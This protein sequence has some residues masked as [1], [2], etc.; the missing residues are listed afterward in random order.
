MDAGPAPSA[1]GALADDGSWQLAFDH[2]GA[3]WLDMRMGLGELLTAETMTPDATILAR[4]GWDAL[5]GSTE[6]AADW[7]VRDEM[8][9]PRPTAPTRHPFADVLLA[10]A[11]G[12]LGRPGRHRRPRRSSA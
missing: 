6:E 4:I 12:G 11:D 10:L 8:R 7:D 5:L 3:T 9:R 2:D 1:H